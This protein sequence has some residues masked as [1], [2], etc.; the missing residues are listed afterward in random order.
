VLFSL[1]LRLAEPTS[2]N[3]EAKARLICSLRNGAPI[4]SEAIWLVMERLRLRI[5]RIVENGS[6]SLDEKHKLGHLLRTHKWNPYC[7]RH[8]AIIRD[9][10]YLPEYAVKKKVRWVMGSKQGTRYVKTKMGDELRNKILEH[11]GIKLTSESTTSAV[12]TCGRCNYIS[13]FES[14]YREDC[15]YPLT[16]L[17][18]DEI[19]KQE[20]F[21]VTEVIDERLRDKV[22]QM[23]SKD[24]EIQELK[25]QMAETQVQVYTI[26]CNGAKATRTIQGMISS[27]FYSGGSD[28]GGGN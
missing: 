12:R 20:E 5:K 8:S 11:S 2:F 16:Q 18:L 13:K 7:F 22:A 24:R 6:I 27:A 14:K 1:C 9:S 28:N 10:D 3:N 4:G 15:N 26:P 23:Q 17:A 25:A 19:K 21:R